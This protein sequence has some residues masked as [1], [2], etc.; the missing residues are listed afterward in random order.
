MSVSVC[1]NYHLEINRD[2][3]TNTV[4]CEKVGTVVEEYKGVIR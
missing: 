1:I 2:I 3:M 4:I